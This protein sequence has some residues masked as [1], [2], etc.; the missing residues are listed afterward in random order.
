[1]TDQQKERLAA[2]IHASEEFKN[3]ANLLGSPSVV[4]GL[5][6][7]FDKGQIRTCLSGDA[8]GILEIIASIITQLRP[9]DFK[10]LRNLMDTHAIF[11]AHRKET[12]TVLPAKPEWMN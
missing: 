7:K 6:V 4:I 9:K 11:A 10:I 1:M 2:L 3:Y 8:V 12:A 5:D